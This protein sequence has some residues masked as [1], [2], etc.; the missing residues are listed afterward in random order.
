M[1]PVSEKIA[2]ILLNLGAPESLAD[3]KPFLRNLF[4]DPDIIDLPMGKI[5]RPLLAWNITRKRLPESMQIYEKIGG[6]SPLR[7]L[8][9][10]QADALEAKLN[11]NDNFKVYLAMRYW[12]PFTEAAVEELITEGIRKVILLPLY[13]QYS[14]TSTG[15]SLHEF[16]RV[17]KKRKD[18]EIEFR[19]IHDYHDVPSYID[20]L[21]EKIRE[22]IEKFNGVGDDDLHILFSAHGVP[23]KV[24]EKGDPY[25]KQVR[26]TVDLAVTKLESRYPHTISFQSKVTKAE[27]LGPATDKII[28]ELGKNGVRNLLVVP[29]AFVNDH[30]ETLFELGIFNRDLAMKAGITRYEVM[31][32]LNDSPKFINVLKELVLQRVESW[33]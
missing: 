23:L 1:N 12:H 15:S 6:G 10:K 33:N 28:P 16:E 3:I 7:K 20:A 8:S 4:N 11:E 26:A 31:P 29:V 27:W 9:Q 30:S 19:F 21:A 13:P 25:E 18:A 22:G 14:I 32:A 24:I 2:V 17:I 5:L